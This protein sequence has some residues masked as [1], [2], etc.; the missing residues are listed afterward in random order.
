MQ[1]RYARSYV[2]QLYEAKDMFALER[3][4]DAV[5]RDRQLPEQFWLCR[6]LFF[7]CGS[8][9]S[10]IWQ[11]YEA[12]A[13]EDFETVASALERFGLHEVASRYRSGMERWRQPNGC[14]E[15][16]GWIDTHQDEL[17]S[18]AFQ[19]IANDRHYLF[20]GH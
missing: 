4:I 13:Q 7:W 18:A 10:G 3:V 15:L 19:L 6:C 16:D 1:V 14:D 11:Y 5:G 17:E 2:D 12:I 20:D 9:R 8:S